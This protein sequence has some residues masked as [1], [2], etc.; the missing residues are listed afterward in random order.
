[1]EQ[2]DDTIAAVATPFG[3]GAVAVVRVSGSAASSLLAEIFSSA[4]STTRDLEPRR[5]Y[6]GKVVD[7]SSGDVVDEALVTFFPGPASYTGDDLVE[8][9]CHGGVHVTR[10][11]LE[12]VLAAGARPAG[13]G[14]FTQRAFLNG[15]M[16]LTQAEAVMDLIRSRSDLALVSAQAQLSGGLGR[17]MEAMRQDLLGVLAHLEAYI[18]FPEEGI[19]PQTG[20]SMVARMAAARDEIARLLGT[21]ERGRI[22]RDGV[23]TVICGAPNVGKSSLL[24]A[25]SGRDRAIVSE[26]AGTTRDTIEE[27]IHVGGFALRLIDTAGMRESEDVI[28]REGISRTRRA[29]GEADLIIEVVD[30]SRAP[31]DQERVAIDVP[32]AARILVL[33]KVDLGEDP[34]W[35]RAGDVRISCTAETGIH[36]LAGLVERVI[37]AGRADFGRDPIAINT[38]HQDCLRRA[39]E[40]LEVAIKG[41]EEEA[42][43]ELVAIDIRAALDTIGEVVGKADTEDV[44]GEI[45]ANFCIGK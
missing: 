4:A 12:A 9:A 45:F 44:L 24:N 19:D 38:R 13:P 25:L 18:D 27:A 10:R 23:A 22:L 41:L 15:K 29:L 37:G 36:K 7:P 6:L 43:T 3:E 32:A 1:M 20:V 21:A 28:E 26:L 14:E 35:A 33:N 16:D 8:I 42:F 11:V 5:Q 39:C 34:A 31:D 30:A 17:G 40:A 2:D